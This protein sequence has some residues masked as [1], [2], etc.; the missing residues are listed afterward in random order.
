MSGAGYHCELSVFSRKLSGVFMLKTSRSL[1][2]QRV[3]TQ[4]GIS[5]VPLALCTVDPLSLLQPREIWLTGGHLICA[6]QWEPRKERPTGR[7]KPRPWGLQV[8]GILFAIS[9]L[10]TDSSSPGSGNLASH[11]SL[12]PTSL[13][14]LGKTG[15][16][17]GGQGRGGYT[18]PRQPGCSRGK[19]L[20]T[21]TSPFTVS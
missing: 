5:S 8:L 11:Q 10:K 2:L 9:H 15:K 21:A 18:P 12:P 3:V 13:P 1:T 7:D 16:A 19:E 14:A 6:H 4:C 17:F 20:L